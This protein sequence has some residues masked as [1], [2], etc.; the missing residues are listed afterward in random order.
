[1]WVIA[2][3]NDF[4]SVSEA[5]TILLL[6]FCQF[7]FSVP[8]CT[9]WS[10]T[11][12]Y[13]CRSTKNRPSKRQI[14]KNEIKF[15][16]PKIKEYLEEKV[17]HHIYVMRE[18]LNVDNLSL[19]TYTHRVAWIQRSGYKFSKIFKSRFHWSVAT[20]KVHSYGAWPYTKDTSSLFIQMPKSVFKASGFHEVTENDGDEC[21]IW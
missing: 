19:R 18:K 17:K 10:L 16:C 21:G 11:S 8:A 4:H 12:P 13:W 5:R 2:K 7:S 1:M 15:T 20:A 3:A 6:K 9:H 14:A